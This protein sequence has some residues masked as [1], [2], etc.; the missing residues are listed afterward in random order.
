MTWLTNAPRELRSV[1]VTCDLSWNKVLKNTSL[2][3]S[4]T[5][6]REKTRSHS[7]GALQSVSGSRRTTSNL[8]TTYSHQLQASWPDWRWMFRPPGVL[9]RPVLLSK[10]VIKIGEFQNPDNAAESQKDIFVLFHSESWQG[11]QKPC[12]G[13]HVKYLSWIRKDPN[14]RASVFSLPKRHTHC[15]TLRGTWSVWRNCQ[16][17][18]PCA[19][20]RITQCW[21]WLCAPTSRLLPLQSSIVRGTHLL[22]CLVSIKMI[23][24]RKP[25]LKADL[26]LF[27][28]AFSDSLLDR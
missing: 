7:R 3:T 18:A 20:S 13:G 19:W 15:C 5:L 28:V 22:N 27:T 6:C 26:G 16:T 9:C 10:N 8:E 12:I 1:T 23:Q 21:L 24:N 17:L 11:Q 14:C 2:P 4:P 25:S